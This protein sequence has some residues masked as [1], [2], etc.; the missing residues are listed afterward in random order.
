MKKRNRCFDTKCDVIGFVR[1][2]QISTNNEIIKTRFWI[3]ITQLLFQY[4]ILWSRSPISFTYLF[5]F[6]II[7][8]SVQG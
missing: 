2:L 1:W 5:Q 3:K 6:N 4:A 7:W 8:R